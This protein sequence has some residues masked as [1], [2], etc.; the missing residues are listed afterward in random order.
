MPSN[1]DLYVHRIIANHAPR[2]VEAVSLNHLIQV[3]QAWAGQYLI[4]LKYSGSI[5]KGTAI[6][7]SSDVDLFVSLSAD[8]LTGRTP[9][10][11]TL[12]ASLNNYLSA[13]GY[14]TRQ[15]NVSIRVIAAGLSVDIVPGVKHRGNTNDHSL[16]KRKADTWRQTNIDT[17][18]SH[19]RDSGR[20]PE[21]KGIKIWRNLNGL[22]MSSF[23]LELVVLR[24]LHGK[25]FGNTADNLMTS[26]LFL[27]NDFPNASIYDPAN[28]NN[29]ISDELTAA[30][31]TRVA[32]VARQ[33]AGQANWGSIIW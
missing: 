1:A 31:K 32:T 18:I 17:H 4:A 8:V 25:R 11:S 5:A 19:V 6:A 30:E 7:G 29:C 20:V 3:I 23:Y 27:A 33:S 9:T 12:Y 24:A 2:S 10:L 26:L 21:I 28:T 22:D 15:Q 13:A 16:Y 14:V